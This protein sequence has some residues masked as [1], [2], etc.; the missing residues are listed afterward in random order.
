MQK[1]LRASSSPRQVSPN[2]IPGKIPPFQEEIKQINW[3]TRLYPSSMSVSAKRKSRRVLNTGMPWKALSRPII[4]GKSVTKGSPKSPKNLLFTSQLPATRMLSPTLLG[5]AFNHRF[6]SLNH[7]FSI[8]LL[9]MPMFHHFT[10]DTRP[11]IEWCLVLCGFC[12]SFL[13]PPPKKPDSIWIDSM[14]VVCASFGFVNR[15][16]L[17]EN[18]QPGRH[19]FAWF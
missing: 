17:N 15:I 13:A 5:F 10:P 12:G 6:T 7:L 3:F 4:A 9:Q 8:L 1:I 11:Q 14:G 18:W 16:C 19:F 2:G